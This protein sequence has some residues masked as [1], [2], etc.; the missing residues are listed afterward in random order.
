M[1]NVFGLRVARWRETCGGLH[2]PVDAGEGLRDRAAL[3]FEIHVFP[4]VLG[5][6]GEMTKSMPSAAAGCRLYTE[7]RACRWWTCV[8]G[9]MGVRKSLLKLPDVRI[10]R[11]FKLSIH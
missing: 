7:K 1:E 3:L 2:N 9:D 4:C 11:S 5:K 6:V 10:C 8:D